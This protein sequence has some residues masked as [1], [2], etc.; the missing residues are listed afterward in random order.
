MNV[1]RLLQ[2]KAHL[3]RIAS[4]PECKQFVD[5]NVWFDRG[6]YEEPGVNPAHCRT[7]G[8]IAGYTCELFYGSIRDVENSAAHILGLSYD[9]GLALFHSSNWGPLYSQRLQEEEKEVGSLAY[10][11]VIAEYIDYF[12]SSR[13]KMQAY[14]EE[15]AAKS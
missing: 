14:E 11:K 5:M 2:V 1:E 7:V 10:V 13:Q 8:C 12:I 4:E 15:A 3:L 6:D 9:Q